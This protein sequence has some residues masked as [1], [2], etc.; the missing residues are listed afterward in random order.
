MRL[1]LR[2][3]LPRETDWEKLVA[4]AFPLLA[5]FATLWLK[6][7]LPS[8]PCTLKHTTG[9]PCAGCGGTRATFAMMHGHWS[10]AFDLNPLATLGF[11]G[12]TAYWIFSMALI[13]RG[14]GRR[15]RADG[16][17]RGGKFCVR[18]GIVAM[19]LANWLWVLT[20]LPE[21]PWHAQ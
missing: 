7:G 4:I 8:P 18:F 15:L 1:S 5:A 16:M 21:S 19:L 12:A 10:E 13:F 20:H 11:I 14:S 2:P 3:L 6:L 9:I 17:T